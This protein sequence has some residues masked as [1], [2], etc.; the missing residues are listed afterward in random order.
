MKDS[1]RLDEPRIELLPLLLFVAATAWVGSFII[2]ALRSKDLFLLATIIGAIYTGAGVIA[3]LQFTRSHRR[4][5]GGETV[6]RNNQGSVGLEADVASVAEADATTTQS[7]S[8]FWFVDVKA[9][10]GDK[11]LAT[12]YAH[13]GGSHGSPISSLG[14]DFSAI[15]YMAIVTATNGGIV[16]L[17]SGKFDLA[18]VRKRLRTLDVTYGKYNDVELW[19]NTENTWALALLDGFILYGD[20]A[21]VKHCTDVIQGP[22]R[23]MHDDT[24]FRNVAQKLETGI[25][26]RFESRTYAGKQYAGLLVSGW[27]AEKRDANTLISTD[28]L[29]FANVSAASD[30][31]A[32][33]FVGATQDGQFL[34]LAVDRSI[35]DWIKQN[36]KAG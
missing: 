4:G 8:T 33:A 14:V 34:Q 11:E 22:E 2:L 1:K 17:F 16:K 13:L 31:R 32:A 26:M 12:L 5:P 25:M 35:A 27:S 36:P 6:S 10:R 30:A 20:A 23:S 15:D 19:A 29:E 21:G 18:G 9:T 24:N 28:I 7:L 3:F